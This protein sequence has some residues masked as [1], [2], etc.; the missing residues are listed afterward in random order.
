MLCK[1]PSYELGHWVRNRANY[2]DIAYHY[3]KATDQSFI[4]IYDGPD[5][6]PHWKLMLENTIDEHLQANMLKPCPFCGGT[7]RIVVCDDEGNIHDEAYEKDPWSGLGYRLCHE[8][9]DD[10]TGEC[11]IAG[12]DGEGFLGTFIYDTREE[13]IKACNRRV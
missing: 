3:N 11:P 9:A 1:I 2:G 6:N 10:P 5:N 8:T 12:Y 4:Y 13:A 7:F